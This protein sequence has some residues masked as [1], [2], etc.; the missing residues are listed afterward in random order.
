[1]RPIR[2]DA[3]Q[4]HNVDAQK[5]AAHRRS[6]TIAAEI[7]A[8]AFLHEIQNVVQL[9]DV[10]CVCERILGQKSF[11]GMQAPAGFR[12]GSLAGMEDGKPQVFPFHAGT[13][14][15]GH[16]TPRGINE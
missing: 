9:G 7:Q 14:L 16:Y 13:I 2:A 1:M 15:R 10:F 6:H 5:R 12:E 11:Q 3:E 8:A 4:S